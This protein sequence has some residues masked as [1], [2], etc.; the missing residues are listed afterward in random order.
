MF[1]NIA[2]DDETSPNSEKYDLSFGLIVEILEEAKSIRTKNK[3]LL[4]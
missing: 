3:N 1:T 4:N 2:A